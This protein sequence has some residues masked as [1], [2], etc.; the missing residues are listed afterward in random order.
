MGQILE[1]VWGAECERLV[2][3]LKKL[4]PIITPRTGSRA[5][6]EWLGILDIHK[7]GSP[8]TDLIKR[9]TQ[10]EIGGYFDAISIRLRE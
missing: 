2:N 8:P 10:L 1:Q 5:Y 7:A 3:L 4:R 9:G 6:E